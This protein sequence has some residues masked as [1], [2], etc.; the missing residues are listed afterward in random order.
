MWP[1]ADLNEETV[2]DIFDRHI[3]NKTERDRRLCAGFLAKE[4]GFGGISLVR[5]ATGLSRV[6][7]SSGK[8]ELSVMAFR[9]DDIWNRIFRNESE[10]FPDAEHRVRKPGGGRKRIDHKFPDL[11]VWIKGIIEEEDCLHEKAENW[12]ITDIKKQL[13]KKYGANIGLNTIERNVVQLGY[14]KSK[15]PM[16]G[17]VQWMRF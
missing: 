9:E 1:K 3:R 12:S 17:A 8:R 14:H 15:N 4:I 2:R 13:N 10:V 5:K 11:R 6:T 16:T 7:I